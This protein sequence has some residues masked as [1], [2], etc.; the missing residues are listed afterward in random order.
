MC[1]R[2]VKFGVLLDYVRDLGFDYLA[3]GHYAKIKKNKGSSSAKAGMLAQDDIV[4]PAGDTGLPPGPALSDLKQAGLKTKIQGPTISIAED[5]LVAKKGEAISAG[6]ANALGKLN[7]K[8]IK[9]GL[10]LVACYEH[11]EMLLQMFLTLILMKFFQTLFLLI[12]SI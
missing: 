1:N 6:V 8:P 12:K 7:I 4:I 11:G 10:N 5:K 2:L 3:T 9:I